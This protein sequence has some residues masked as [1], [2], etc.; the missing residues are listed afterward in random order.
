M[1]QVG[2]IFVVLGFDNSVVKATFVDGT[3]VKINAPKFDQDTPFGG[4][5]DR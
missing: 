2:W 1:M 5:P 4:C 3:T